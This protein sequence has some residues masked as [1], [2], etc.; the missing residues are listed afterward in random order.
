[1]RGRTWRRRY[2]GGDGFLE[3]R[4]QCCHR[5]PLLLNAEA[6]KA[7]ERVGANAHNTRLHVITAGKLYGAV[8]AEY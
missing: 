3:S 2:G 8:F 4:F 1:M 7:R 6:R 5:S